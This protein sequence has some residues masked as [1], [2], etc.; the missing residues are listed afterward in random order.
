M[1]VYIMYICLGKL[2]KYTTLVWACFLFSFLILNL[3]N[4]S[5]L[6][7]RD[8]FLTFQK[9]PKPHLGL[10]QTTNA[11]FTI[12]HQNNDSVIIVT[13]INNR[14]DICRYTFQGY[15]FRFNVAILSHRTFVCF[16]HL[17]GRPIYERLIDSYFNFV[18]LSVLRDSI[19]AASF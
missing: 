18:A 10:L 17:V 12:L 9:L 16:H 19:L 7:N 2:C 4:C 1:H 11:L 8:V 5:V 15:P 6:S 14:P 13:I 3:K